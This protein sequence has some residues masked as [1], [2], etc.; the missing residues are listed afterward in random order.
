MHTWKHTA[1]RLITAAALLTAIGAGPARAQAP[2]RRWLL[3]FD[4]VAGTI[5]DNEQTADIAINQKAG[6]LGLQ[7]GYRLKPS[8]MLRFSAI[9]T[10]HETSDPDVTIRI[11]GG[12]LD[13]V[14]LFR[15]GNPFRTYLFA[16]LGVYQAA[17]RQAALSYSVRGPGAAFG[18]GAYRQLGG[19]A[20]LH[21]SLRVES[22]NWEKS[23]A[24]WEQPGG[25][26]EVAAPIDEN[27]WTSKVMLGVG[28]WL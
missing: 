4:A 20:T 25:R 12:T 10:D 27:G 16:G 15:E 22:V 3:G 2:E 6:G 8:F 23:G 11:G 26:N 21:G 17:S 18:V 7:L 13:A 24:T 9:A 28:F 5:D 19:C 1:R 14:F